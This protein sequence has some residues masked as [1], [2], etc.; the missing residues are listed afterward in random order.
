MS[1]STRDFPKGEGSNVHIIVYVPSTKNV[2]EKISDAEFKKRVGEAKNFLNRAFGGTTTVK[3]VGSY[4]AENG[5][6]QE[7]VALVETFTKKKDYNANDLKIKK[8]LKDIIDR[9]V[10]NI[11]S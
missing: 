8:G 9:L 5:L 1:V 6:V 4:T 7:N 2:S 11:R 3:G 10:L